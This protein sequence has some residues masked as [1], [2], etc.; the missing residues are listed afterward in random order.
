MS[1]PQNHRSP[2]ADVIDILVSVDI[3][4]ISP[5]GLRHERRFAAN[6][7]EGARRAVHP[8]RNHAISAKKGLMTLGK[9]NSGFDV[10]EVLGIM[11][12]QK[13]ATEKLLLDETTESRGKPSGRP[14]N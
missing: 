6:R 1:V 10:A 2:R 8:A 5:L 11:V 12:F 13:Y 3:K 4:E 14:G 9:R 7:P